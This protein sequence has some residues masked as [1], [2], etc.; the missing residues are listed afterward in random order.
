M[1]K[2][3]TRNRIIQKADTLFYEVGFEATSFADIAAALG[4]SRGNFYH[5][6]RTKDEILDAVIAYR[7]DKTWAMLSAWEDTSPAPR[8]RILCFVRILIV[9]RDKIMA[10]GCPVGT[11]S[12]ELAKLNHAAHGRATE[13]FALFRDWLTSQFR[14]LGAGKQAEAHALHVLSWSQGVASIAAAF[15]D[16]AFIHREAAGIADWLDTLKLQGD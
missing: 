1:P 13:I 10:F 3:S 14:A 4:L 8:N 12:A 5:H 15:R 11:L 9:N 2:V 6:F 7:L 16:D